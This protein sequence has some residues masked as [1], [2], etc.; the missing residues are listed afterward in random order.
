M[1]TGNTERH[2]AIVIDGIKKGGGAEKNAVRLA[3]L[4]AASGERV[5]VLTFNTYT[6]EYTCTAHRIS[7]DDTTERSVF[8]KGVTGCRRL[9]KLQQSYAEQKITHVVS[10]LEKANLYTVVVRILF[11]NQPCLILSVR[12]DPT[13][14][15]RINRY[16]IKLLYRYADV[17]VAV[18]CDLEQVLRRDF[19]ITRAVTIT[20]PVNTEVIEKLSQEALPTEFQ[21]VQKGGY[22]PVFINIGRLRTQKGQKYL[23]ASFARVVVKYPNALL[24]IVGEG[25]E[26]SVLERVIADY[27]LEKRVLLVGQQVNV[28]PFLRIADCFVFPSLFEGFPNALLEAAA[29][30]KYVISTDCHTGPREIIAPETVGQEITYP[31]RVPGGSLLPDFTNLHSDQDIED[32]LYN[33]MLWFAANQEMLTQA[34]SVQRFSEDVFM[35]KWIEIM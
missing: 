7:F 4:L 3:N 31:Y 19:G 25:S 14:T 18:S 9:R 12:A 23:I 34:L 22:Y 20:N 6:H 27:S 35:K 26:R 13:F 1:T 5:S 32:I 15:S 24:L 33:E 10:F 16:L 8:A 2:I 29:I 11:R 17:V 28:F 30:G 21:V